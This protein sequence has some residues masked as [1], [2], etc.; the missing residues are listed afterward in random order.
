[1]PRQHEPMTLSLGGPMAEI[2][3]DRDHLVT[4]LRD[5]VEPLRQAALNAR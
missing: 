1:M 5:A 3:Q 2:E 4:L